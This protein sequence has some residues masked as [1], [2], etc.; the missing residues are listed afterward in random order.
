MYMNVCGQMSTIDMETYT[1][2][3]T[4]TYYMHGLQALTNNAYFLY[5]SGLKSS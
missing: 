1:H 5:E 3:N 2:V 4:I